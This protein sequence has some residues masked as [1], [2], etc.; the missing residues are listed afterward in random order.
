MVESHW[1][2]NEAHVKRFESKLLKMSDGCIEWTGQRDKNGYGVLNISQ[3]PCRAH[4]LSLARSIGRDLRSGEQS[5]HICDNPPCVNPRHLRVG[6]SKDNAE[7]RVA[8][9]QQARGERQGL[10]VLTEAKVLEIRA[11]LRAGEMTMQSIADRYGISRPTV[12]QIKRR[13]TWTHLPEEP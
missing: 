3:Y 8:R 12:G 2:L 13:V 9:G 6:T 7:D 11:L 4:R 5:L 10:A 1:W